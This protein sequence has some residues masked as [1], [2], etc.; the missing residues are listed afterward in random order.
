MESRQLRL[1]PLE[2]FVVLG[3]LALLL[4]VM[5]PRLSS[6][7]IGS[8]RVACASNLRSLG[9]AILMCASDHG[10][11]FPDT[12]GDVVASSQHLPDVRILQCPACDDTPPTGATPAA[13]AANLTAGGHLS[14]VYVAKGLTLRTP[15]AGNIVLAYEHASHHASAEGKPTGGNVLFADGHVAWH[16]AAELRAVIDWHAAGN[17]PMALAKGRRRSRPGGPCP[18]A[19]R[20]RWSRE[21]LR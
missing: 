13:R 6:P 15:G 1:T 17:G 21:S 14:Y 8:V 2:W 4:T 11:R 10:G 18:R 20:E 19:P 9:Q 3:L 7:R 12:L 16:S 5:M